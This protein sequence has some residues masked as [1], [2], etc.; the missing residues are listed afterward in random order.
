MRIK[1][2]FSD[3]FE[4]DYPKCLFYI[5]KSI[6][7]IDD[8]SKSIYESFNLSKITKGITLEIDQI[9]GYPLLPFQPVKLIKEEDVIK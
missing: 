4:L 8:L 2:N 9:D 5:E 6:K 3:D 1:L 7:T